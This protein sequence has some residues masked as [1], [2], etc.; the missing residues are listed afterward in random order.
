MKKLL[1]L[2][3][4]VSLLVPA[5]VRAYTV[6]TN[7]PRIWIEPEDVAGIAADAYT[8]GK[9]QT[10]YAAVKSWVDSHINDSPSGISQ[11]VGYRTCDHAAYNMAYHLMNTSLVYLVEKER[12]SSGYA[13]YGQRVADLLYYLANSGS[14]VYSH[15][16]G[17]GDDYGM[18]YPSLAVAYDWCRDQLNYAGHLATISDYLSDIASSA[19]TSN[20]CKHWTDSNYEPR[21][22][23]EPWQAG[24]IALSIY[25]E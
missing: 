1:P 4:I 21:K 3:V 6:T 18:S 2:L 17:S 19:V 20:T 10:Q 22:T 16:A 11:D 9:A 12:A 5:S 15:S 8:A 13:A 23:E 25:G 24:T 7:R 14:G